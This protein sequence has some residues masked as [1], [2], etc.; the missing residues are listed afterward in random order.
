MIVNVDTGTGMSRHLNK[1]YMN[2]NLNLNLP[3]SAIYPLPISVVKN[4]FGVTRFEILECML[5]TTHQ[6]TLNGKVRILANIIKR[7]ASAK[8]ESER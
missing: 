6:D 5:L 2:L 8:Y 4:G 7:Y 1:P 3:V